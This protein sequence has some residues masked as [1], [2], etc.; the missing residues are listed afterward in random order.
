MD[1]PRA[2]TGPPCDREPRGCGAA[3]L[4]SRTER[5]QVRANVGVFV[6]RISDGSSVGSKA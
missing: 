1:A 2:L 5:R 3:R 6:E 4:V